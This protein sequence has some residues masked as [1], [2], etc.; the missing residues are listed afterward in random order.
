MLDLVPPLPARRSELVIRPLGDHGPYVV[1]D[2]GTGAYYHLGV[3]EHLLLS[4]LDGQCDAEAI[5]AAF[6]ERFGQPLAGQ[7]LHEFLEM[8]KDQGFLQSCNDEMPGAGH[9]SKSAPKPTEA[10]LGLRLLYWRK[11]FFDPDRF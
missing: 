10:P 4:Q 7:E 8:A 6:L 11:N 9:A 5:R 3:E 2:P 1:K